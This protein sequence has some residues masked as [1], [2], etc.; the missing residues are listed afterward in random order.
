MY[1]SRLR[2][3]P[4]AAVRRSVYDAHQ[5]LWRLFSDSPSRTRDFLY[6]EIDPWTFVAVSARPPGQA[7]GLWGVEIK[8]YAPRL[9]VGD[10]LFVSLRANAVIKRGKTRHDVV[11]QARTDYLSRGEEPPSRAE[12]AQSAGRVWL[13]AR[14]EAMGLM[15]EAESIAADGY[16]PQRFRSHGQKVSISTLDLSGIAA[17]ADPDKALAA[18]TRG[19]G[20]AK[21]FGCGLILARR[22]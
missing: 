17:V 16:A 21:G 12:L 5:A 19:V 3:D 7:E 10:R 18:M 2:L 8:P 4:R 1:F 14:Q 6:R 13:V 22:A 15:F 20:P 9:A 11:Q